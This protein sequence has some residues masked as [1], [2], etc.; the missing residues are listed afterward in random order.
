MI[1]TA[2]TIHSILKTVTLHTLF[3]SI[4]MV[5]GMV[6][7]GWKQT[8]NKILSVLFAAFCCLIFRFFLYESESLGRHP[9]LNVIV[10]A[11]IFLLGPMILFLARLSVDPSF[12]IDQQAFRHSIP[13]IIKTYIKNRT[14]KA[15][16]LCFTTR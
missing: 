7:S 5:I 12:I 11:G 10:P 3:L 16:N 14:I 15:V 9:Q 1:C 13:A 8:G 2:N 6:V 4:L